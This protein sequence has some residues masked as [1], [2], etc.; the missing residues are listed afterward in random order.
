MGRV[1][2][3]PKVIAQ[4]MKP[5]SQGQLMQILSFRCRVLR[6]VREH[7]IRLSWCKA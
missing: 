6:L 1:Q 7:V 5:S 4:S 3:L 2:R